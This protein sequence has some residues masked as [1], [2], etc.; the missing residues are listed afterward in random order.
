MSGSE[1]QYL[2]NLGAF[3]ETLCG[4]TSIRIIHLT[5]SNQLASLVSF[6]IAMN[7]DNWIG[8]PYKTQGLTL[9]PLDCLRWFKSGRSLQSH[10]NQLFSNQSILSIDYESLTVDFV[11]LM[12][13]IYCFLDLPESKSVLP[14]LEKQQTVPLS[15]LILNYHEL[16]TYFYGSEWSSYFESE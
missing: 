11:N 4:D 15:R 7:E 12:Q 2:Q 9:D 10:Y 8:R 3:W 16:K 1:E 6:A 13:R 5:R 14:D